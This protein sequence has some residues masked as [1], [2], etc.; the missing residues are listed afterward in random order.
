[1]HVQGIRVDLLRRKGD[2]ERFL[3][4]Q[5]E[6]GDI[7]RRW[8]SAYCAFMWE[9]GYASTA[10]IHDAIWRIPIAD[11]DRAPD[12]RELTRAQLPMRRAFDVLSWREEGQEAH[13][14]DLDLQ[15]DVSS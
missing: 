14:L 3:P 2:I 12:T 9:F 1:M 8:L 7:I 6:T 15:R 10:A 5:H 13:D 11:Q 4:F